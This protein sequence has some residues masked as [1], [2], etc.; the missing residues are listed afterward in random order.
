MHIINQTKKGDK[1]MENNTK[2]TQ[3][4]EKEMLELN[5]QFSEFLHT[6]GIVAK[7]KLAFNNMSESAK[8]QHE[9]DV[10]NFEA[11]K[12][13]SAEDNKEFVEFLQTKGIKAKYNLVIENLKKGIKDA[14]ANTA[15]QIAKTKA[16]TQA[17]VAHANSL[18]H[19]KSATTVEVTA[20]SLEEEFN[21]FLKSK[22]LDGKYTVTVTE[23]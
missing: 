6:K 17:A 12:A 15:A 8:K 23:E 22:G 3:E 4:I 10:E 21:E 5:N 9:A 1:K 16:Q 7:F 19:Q 2:T 14:P 11:V 13:K 18:G 20:G